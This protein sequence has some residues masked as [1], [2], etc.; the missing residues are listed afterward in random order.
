MWVKSENQV[1]EVA[2]CAEHPNLDEVVGFCHDKF[3][4]GRAS[5]ESAERQ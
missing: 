2:W 5:W 4:A 3:A 1:T